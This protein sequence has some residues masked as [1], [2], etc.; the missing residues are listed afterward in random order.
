MELETGFEPARST[1]ACWLQISRSGQL[2]YSSILN[3]AS[4]SR[5]YDG[6]V[7]VPCLTAW[8]WRIKSSEVWNPLTKT[9]CFSSDYRRAGNNRWNRKECST[10]LV[11]CEAKATSLMKRG[12]GAADE[13]RTR[14]NLLGGQ[15]LY[16]LNYSCIEYLI[17]KNFLSV[18]EVERKT[19]MWGLLMKLTNQ[20]YR[21]DPLCSI[22]LSE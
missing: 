15:V 8:R 19:K 20:I 4:R 22:N 7:K 14:N 18:C 13:S 10:S 2:S 1:R 3:C 12:R 6:G 9:Y 16:Q 21:K 11:R 17:S 5:T